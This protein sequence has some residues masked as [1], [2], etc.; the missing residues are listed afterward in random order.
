[1]SLLVGTP[2]TVPKRLERSL[3]ELKI[4][5][6]I[7]TTALLGS[8]RILSIVLE[9]GGDLL[10]HRLKGKTINYHWCEKLARSKMIT[11]EA[12]INLKKTTCLTVNFIIPA[13]KRKL[14]EK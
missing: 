12:S 3:E 7:E 14:K 4:G 9:T 2:G 1:M 5:G 8:D 6:G 13:N 10:S 11:I